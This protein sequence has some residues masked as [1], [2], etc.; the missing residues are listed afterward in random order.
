[1]AT[2]RMTTGTASL[3]GLY[4]SAYLEKTFVSTLKKKLLCAKFG[5]DSTITQGQGAT[6]VRW[7]YFTAPS[8]LTTTITNGADPA[9]YTD[10]TTTTAEAT[11]IEYGGMTDFQRFLMET[12]LSGT[13]E[14]FAEMLGYQAALT[15]DTLAISEIDGSSTSVDS[16]TAM[17][18]DSVR[19]GA[20]A[21]EVADAQFHP[22]AGG[23][24]YVGL[25]HADSLYDMLGEGSPAWFQAKDA[26]VVGATEKPFRDNVPSAGLYN[27]LLHK[28][29]NV[30]NVTSEYLNVLIADDSFGV[31]ALNTNVLQPALIRT[32]P[33]ELVSAPIRNRGTIGWR[34]VFAAKL[35]DSN[36][37]A[38]VKADI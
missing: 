1:M 10:H 27:C 5:K 32:M 11:L 7:Q 13:I 30:Q 6:V 22:A 35:F 14:K 28:T 38:V 17:T 4:T 37:V 21:L 16:G 8:A 24:G 20:R 18:A 3:A 23:Q 2:N 29:N 15:I 25:F 12:A 34:V 19:L 9:A 31:A 33:D 26:N 36:R